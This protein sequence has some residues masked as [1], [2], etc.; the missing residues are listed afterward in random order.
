MTGTPSDVQTATRCWGPGLTRGSPPCLGR[1]LVLHTCQHL[2]TA[3][4]PTQRPLLRASALGPAAVLMAEGTG[5]CY[6]DS[7]HGVSESPAVVGE[8]SEQFHSSFLVEEG[9]QRRRHVFTVT[10][11]ECV[12]AG[13]RLVDE[14]WLS[15]AWADITMTFTPGPQSCRPGGGQC[16]PN[17]P[18]RGCPPVSQLLLLALLLMLPAPSHQGGSDLLSGLR[19]EQLS[20]Y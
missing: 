4:I 15:Q 13:G 9:D 17:A 3:A 16:L 12:T 8:S 7:E 1:C 6:A 14:E 2:S 5:T 18:P 11:G 19:E 20:S 10:Q